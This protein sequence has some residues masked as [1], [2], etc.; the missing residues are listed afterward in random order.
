MLF[1]GLAALWLGDDDRMAAML[2]RE[3]RSARARGA[4]GPLTELL[5]VRSSQLLLAQRFD[6]AAQAAT[7]ALRFAR[8][9]RAENLVATPLTILAYLAA[10]RGDDERRPSRRAR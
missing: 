5:A 4:I 7:E 3:I 1:A 8:E 6:G 10:L 9:V 2:E